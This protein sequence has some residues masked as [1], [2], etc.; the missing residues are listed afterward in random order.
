VWNAPFATMLAV[1]SPCH[2]SPLPH[3]AALAQEQR[4]FQSTNPPPVNWIEMISARIAL[5]WALHAW[6]TRIAREFRFRLYRH[7]GSLANLLYRHPS[8]SELHYTS[9]DRV[10]CNLP[11]TTMIL[12]Y[13]SLARG[14]PGS[15][16]VHPWA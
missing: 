16:K 15:Q 12:Q 9:L 4:L 13:A 8:T 7:S 2:A 11:I 6:A 10:E 3:I 5:D 1:F 14:L